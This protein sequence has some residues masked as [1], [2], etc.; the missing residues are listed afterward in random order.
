MY[1]NRKTVRQRLLLWRNRLHFQISVRRRGWFPELIIH[2]RFKP[3]VKAIKFLLTLLGLFSAFFAFQSVLLA[4]C[5]GL[6]IYAFT[7][8]FESVVFSYTSIFVHP[9]PD[10]TIEPDKW[11]GAYFGYAQQQGRPDIPMIGWIMSDAEYARKVHELLLAWC[12]GEA[13]DR[14]KNIYA[15]AVVDGDSYVFFCCPSMSR[16]TVTQFYKSVETERRK[17]SL[18]DIH[19]KM[20][21]MLVFGKRCEITSTSYFPT[22]RQRYR[23][24]VPVLFRLVLPAA[25]GQVDTMPGLEDFVLFDFKIKEKKNLTR[26]D[27]EFDHFRMRA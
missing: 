5:F 18:T 1:A 14:Q 23:S 13:V 9:M 15:S 26:K 7:T 10:F 25:N 17:Q 2:E 6:V 27:I 8:I 22:F 3:F 20:L 4:F 24:G 16:K 19:Q 11:L 12:Y 21:A